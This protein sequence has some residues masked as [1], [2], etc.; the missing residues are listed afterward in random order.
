[1]ELVAQS[2][3]SSFVFVQEHWLCPSSMSLIQNFSPLLTTFG[4]SAMERVVESGIWRGRPFGGV[5]TLIPNSWLGGVQYVYT[6]ERF[7]LLVINNVVLLNLY[8]PCVARGSANLLAAVLGEVEAQL[9]LYDDLPII[10]GGDLN[11]DIVKRS[12]HS[13]L[14]L[15]FMQ[16][17]RLIA[18]NT[19][20]PPNLDYTYFNEAR[21]QRS[22]TDFFLVSDSLGTKVVKNLMIDQY[23]NMSDHM[24][25]LLEIICPQA[26]QRQVGNPSTTD[27]GSVGGGTKRLRWD[28]A[29]LP[30]YYSHSGDAIY[31]ISHDLNNQL[32][33]LFGTRDVSDIITSFNNVQLDAMRPEALG[34]IEHTYNSLVRSLSNA[35]ADTVPAI[36]AGTMKH[37][38]SPALTGLKGEAQRALKKWRE[39]GQPRAG[40]EFEAL[41]KAKKFFKGA[42]KKQ[43]KSVKEGV[44]RS[45]LQS[46]ANTSSFWKLWRAKM[47]EKKLLPRVINGEFDEAKTAEIF[48]TH[49]NAICSPNS[50]A[51][52]AELAEEF[53]QKKLLYN[54]AE[55]ID[56]YLFSVEVVDKSIDK[57]NTGTSPGLDGI[58]TEHIK[59]AH[60]VLAIVLTKLFNCMLLFGYVPDAFGIGVI[61]PLLKANKSNGKAENYRGISLNPIISKIFEH[62]LLSSFGKFLTTAN[63]QFGFKAKTG[64]AKAI[65]TVRK[66]VDFFTNKGSTVNLCTIDLEKAFDRLN[67]HALFVKLMDR[68]CPIFFINIIQSWYSKSFGIVKWGNS[69]SKK[70]KLQSGTRQGGGMQSRPIF[71]VC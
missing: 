42:I 9:D 52:A 18:C 47:G 50:P 37:W 19:I 6:A 34:V 69:F 41:K 62:C 8:L 43:K 1:M 25:I 46:L 13:D 20:C 33:H 26:P 67:M 2:K 53:E 61:V 57:L 7:V 15:S 40:L 60:P 30:R 23:L 21:N 39:A 45:L 63:T 12:A 55:D 24:P 71:R 44:N 70:F 58:V 22:M 49:F 38:W 56:P 14:V 5:A 28:K 29:Y 16:A 65:Y 35:A 32:D 36:S 54:N 66:V 64:C 17:H 68:R 31:N 27:G 10:C 59:Y 4:Q 11:T 48:A 51:R 3:G